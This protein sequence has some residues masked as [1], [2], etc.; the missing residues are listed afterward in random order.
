VVRVT[1]LSTICDTGG[2]LIISLG[3]TERLP[4]GEIWVG[5]AKNDSSPD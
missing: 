3:S 4:A 2:S 5:N 1:E